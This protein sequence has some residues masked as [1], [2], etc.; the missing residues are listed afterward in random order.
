MDTR[1]SENDMIEFDVIYD[2]DS[3]R[4][5][6]AEDFEKYTKKPS[7]SSSRKKSWQML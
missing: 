5:W 4:E 2:N 6:V 3:G 7:K 1:E